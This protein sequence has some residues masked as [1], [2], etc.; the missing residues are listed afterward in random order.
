MVAKQS[1][2]RNPNTDGEDLPNCTKP[3]GIPNRFVSGKRA[4]ELKFVKGGGEKWNSP[5]L[6][7]SLMPVP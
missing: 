4:A 6:A 5:F 3:K 2:N 1:D 7:S